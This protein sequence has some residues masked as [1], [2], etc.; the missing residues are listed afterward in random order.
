MATS[1]CIEIDQTTAIIEWQWEGSTRTLATGDPDHDAMRFT[2]RLD[3]TEVDDKSYAHFEISIPFRFKD[4]PSGAGVCI[5]VNPFFIKSFNHSTLSNPPGA[6]K[7]IF[8]STTCLD[9]ELD[10][11]VTVLIPSDVKEPVV[12]ARARSGKVLDSLY[13]LSHV[14]SL[15]I[16]IKE[17]LLSLNKF[18][19][20][21]EAVKRRQIRPST[22]PNHD[23]SRMFSDNGGKIATISPPKPPSYDKA[24]KLP[25]NT[26]V[27][28]P[29]VEK[30]IEP[31]L[32]VPPYTRKRPRQDSQ[33]DL[34]RQFLD[35]LNRLESKVQEQEADIAQL[36]AQNAQLRDKV[37]RLE[38]CYEGLE[39]QISLSQA[40][41]N[42]SEEAAMIEI[43]DDIDSL[44][45]RVTTIE[46]V[47]DEEFSEQIKEE[48]FDELAK[49]L[50]G[51]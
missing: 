13:E 44:N 39:T 50:L 5:R 23:I 3:L 49:R 4:K 12:A 38:K 46:S 45:G 1:P 51:G 21:C 33:A 24:T 30:I 19:A 48:I 22:D 8:D 20:I 43:R 26:N 31:P 17:S 47:R 16:Y 28:E 14:T 36:R 32:S 40:H 7:Q 15:R 25:P 11:K 41:G 42:D 37:A 9:F 10:N 18:H 6:V 2:L 34:F 35:K 29:P 27:T